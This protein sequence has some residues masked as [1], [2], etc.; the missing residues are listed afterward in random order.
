MTRGDL[1]D[2]VLRA[3]ARFSDDPGAAHL[4]VRRVAADAGAALR[5]VGRVEEPVSLGSGPLSW[6]CGSWGDE[7]GA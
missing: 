1:A 3:P 5:A 4:S 2:S 6:W 7:V